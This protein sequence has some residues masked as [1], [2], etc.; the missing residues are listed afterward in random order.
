MKKSCEDCSEAGTASPPLS[1]SEGNSG[2]SKTAQEEVAST[3]PET[4]IES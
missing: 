1:K 4:P 2:D 3:P